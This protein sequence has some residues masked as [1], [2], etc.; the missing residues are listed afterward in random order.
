MKRQTMWIIVAV[1][2]G[3]LAWHYYQAHG[4]GAGAVKAK[5]SKQPASQMTGS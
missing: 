1:V 4:M 5:G 2:V 3:Y